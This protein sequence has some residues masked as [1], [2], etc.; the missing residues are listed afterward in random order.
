ME[1]GTL[2][3]TVIGDKNGSEIYFSRSRGREVEDNGNVNVNVYI[4]LL[5]NSLSCLYLTFNFSLI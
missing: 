4:L 2:V 3:F 1:R 5:I